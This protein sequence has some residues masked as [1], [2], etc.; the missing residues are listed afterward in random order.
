MV[1]IDDALI[2][3]IRANAANE[4]RTLEVADDAIKGLRC[5]ASYGGSVGFYLLYRPRGERRMKRVLIGKYPEMKISE[6]RRKATTLK[7]EVSAG[8]DPVQRQK[9]EREARRQQEADLEDHLRALASRMTVRQLAG[10]FLHEKRKL[11]WHG[12]YQQILN[13]NLLEPKLAEMKL[14]IADKA[15][16][17]FTDKNADFKGGHTLFDQD[18]HCEPDVIYPVDAQKNIRQI[19]IRSF[20][21]AQ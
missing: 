2:K 14:G 15:L 6:A 3:R 7:G 10:R 4:R 5:R 1:A 17:D 21:H 13:Y 12:R 11:R 16:E 8:G 18:L 9:E 19:R 20:Q